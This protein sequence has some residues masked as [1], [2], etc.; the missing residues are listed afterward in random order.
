MEVAHLNGDRADSRAENLRYVTRTENN[1]H[2]LFHGTMLKGNKHPRRTIDEAAALAIGERLREEHSHQEVAAEFGTSR[3]V[4]SQ[5]A[6]GRNWRH[7]FPRGWQPPAR[8]RMTPA[9]REK[10]CA[11]VASGGTLRQVAETFGVTPSAISHLI[12]RCRKESAHG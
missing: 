1:H 2:K 9:E 5:I 6:S 8:R 10:A 7:V 4:V 11:M 12:A 3:R